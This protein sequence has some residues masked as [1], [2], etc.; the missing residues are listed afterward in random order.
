[1]GV[2]CRP[3]S[4]NN[5]ADKLFSE[6]L[7]DTSNLT[8]RVLTGDFNLPEINW[9]HHAAATI[10]ARR[11][12]ENLDDHFMEHV[13]RK[14]TQKNALLDLLL[15]NRMDLVNEV[16]I[17][18]HFGHNDH[19]AIEFKISTDRRKTASKT[20]TL[21]IRRADFGLLRELV[22]DMTYMWQERTAGTGCP[23]EDFGIGLLGSKSEYTTEF[24]LKL[25]KITELFTVPLVWSLKQEQMKIQVHSISKGRF[26]L[27]EMGRD[28][29]NKAVQKSLPVYREA[30]HTYH[31]ILTAQ[32]IE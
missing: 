28:L 11:F 31:P 27:S 21:D 4:Q 13:I 24:S 23:G 18:G 9:E 10:R 26:A 32:H 20:S 2:C 16:E 3:P 8:A 19:K 29:K 12:L 1:M 22:G 17:D 25:G 30:L 7:R 6:E 14:L 15:V 5:D